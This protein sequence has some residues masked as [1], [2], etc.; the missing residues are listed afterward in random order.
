MT[1]AITARYAEAR[2]RSGARRSPSC[3]DRDTWRLLVE[4]GVRRPACCLPSSVRS[5]TAERLKMLDA[6]EQA[7]IPDTSVAEGHR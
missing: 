7:L 2:R 4:P 1:V 3:K 5:W 6:M